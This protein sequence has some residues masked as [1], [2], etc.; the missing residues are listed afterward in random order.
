MLRGVDWAKVASYV[1][2]S[3][4][5]PLFDASAAAAPASSGAPAAAI[6]PEPAQ[7]TAAAEEEAAGAAESPRQ[8]AALQRAEAPAVAL[9]QQEELFESA[10]WAAPATPR[11]SARSRRAKALADLG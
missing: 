11:G 10:G 6:A 9:A 3:D 1:D 8:L 7:P 5:L 2:L 4:E